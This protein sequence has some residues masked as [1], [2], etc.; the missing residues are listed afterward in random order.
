VQ[1]ASSPIG[2]MQRELVVRAQ[3]G[4][5]EAFSSM[6]LACSDRLFAVAR[7][8]L[9]ADDRA[10]DAVQDAL[11]Q[12]WLDIRGLKDP[13]RFDAWVYRLLVRACYRS[14]GDHR[15]RAVTEIEIAPWHTPAT[16]DSQQQVALEDC[17]ARSFERLSREQRAVVVLHHYAGLSL[18]EAAAALQIPLGTMQ[19]RL[20]R[21]LRAM[22]AAIEADERL[23]ELAEVA[24]P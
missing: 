21:A 23:T 12:A 10:A 3:R 19:S 7:L 9:R 13:D 24:V 2:P 5:L 15:R 17:L 8:I 6:T 11:L 18:V 20:S 1:G 22:R 14:A 4:D 16:P